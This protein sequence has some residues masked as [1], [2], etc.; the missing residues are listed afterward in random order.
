MLR[1]AWENGVVFSG[2]RVLDVG[3]GSGATTIRIAQE[4]SSVTA[5]DLSEEMLRLLKEDAQALGIHN[6]TPVLASWDDFE[7]DERFGIVFAGTTPAIRD[8]T[9]REKLV[10][11][12]KDW[13]I[14]IGFAAWMISDMTTEL[15]KHYGLTP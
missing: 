8:D 11:F 15:L 4:A 13:V 10:R 1:I 2:K 6:I 5:L 12:S 3:C 14:F 9:S 7:I